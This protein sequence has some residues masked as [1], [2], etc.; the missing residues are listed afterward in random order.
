MLVRHDALSA[1]TRAAASFVGL[2]ART[3]LLRLGC[4]LAKARSGDGS[5]R[6]VFL[7]LFGVARRGW[8]A[9]F[10]VACLS[11][12]GTR[13]RGTTRLCYALKA[14]TSWLMCSC[15]CWGL[16]SQLDTISSVMAPGGCRCV[17]RKARCSKSVSAL[18]ARES[19]LL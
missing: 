12:M 4:C 19:Y 5:V 10:F 6:C 8:C 3:C 9:S 7:M 17:R 18:L 14:L 16:G 1:P 11:V 15:C 2:S 13:D